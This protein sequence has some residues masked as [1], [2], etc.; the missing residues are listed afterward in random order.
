MEIQTPQEETSRVLALAAAL[1]AAVVAI[2]AVDGAFARFDAAELAAAAAFV[3]VFA[4]ASLF[5]D[6]QL[7]RY[8]MQMEAP[9]AGMLA[10]GFAAALAIALAI[11]SAPFAMFFAP[12]AALSI[13]A[14]A[15]LRRPGAV[16]AATPRSSAKSPG[17]TR[18]A[19]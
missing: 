11:A 2:G 5:L 10:V 19:T 12:L 13:A 15:A 14:A 16:R 4:V 17:A 9:R 18:A 3:S 7:R 1:W 6:A 8:A